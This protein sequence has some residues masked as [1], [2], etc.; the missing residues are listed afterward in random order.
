MR[1]DYLREDSLAE[2]DSLWFSKSNFMKNRSNSSFQIIILHNQLFFEKLFGRISSG[3]NLEDA[4][5]GM[6]N[7]PKESQW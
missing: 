3:F 1:V 5:G 4:L 6:L 2:S 7:G